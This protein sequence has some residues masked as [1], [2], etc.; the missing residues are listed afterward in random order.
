MPIHNVARHILSK[1]GKKAARK[2][3]GSKPKA[4]APLTGKQKEE[5]VAK[6]YSSFIKVPSPGSRGPQGQIY[7]RP[8]F[9]TETQINLQMIDTKAKIEK[10]FRAAKTAMKQNIRKKER[11]WFSPE[12]L[13][14]LTGLEARRR[15][16]KIK[17]GKSRV[18]RA[19]LDI[20]KRKFNRKTKKKYRWED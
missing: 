14:E 7:P 1:M 19:I 3:F 13:K 20:E 8:K 17:L 9:V 6:R 5:I 11:E 16:R 18:G 10:A 12:Q 15:A 4:Q 2:F